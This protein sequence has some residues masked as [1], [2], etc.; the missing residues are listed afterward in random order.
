MPGIIT[1]ISGPTVVARNMRT[2]KMYNLVFVGKMRLLGE[3]IRIDGDRATIQVYEETTGL[4]LGDEI[5]DTGEPLCVELG[6]G[7]LSNIFD[8]V[9]RP[10]E[11]IAKGS[12]GF[13]STETL[14]PLNLFQGQGDTLGVTIPSLNRARKWRFVP[15]VKGG[16]EVEE[17]DIIGTIQ[18][19]T[20]ITHRVMVPPDV[21]GVI[22]EISEG[23]FSVEDGIAVLEGGTDIT[24]V[25]KWP[26]RRP[27]PFKKKAASV[28]PFITG[29]RIIDTL[30]PIAMG[31]SVIIPGGFGTGKTVLE[32]TLAKFAKTDI[33]IYIGC[34]ERGNE[35]AEVLADFPGLTDPYTG[36]PLMDRTTLVVN[37]SNMPVAA[38]EASIYTGITI[39]EYYRDMGYNVAV[40]ADSISRWAEAMR[41]I[42]GR[43]EELPGEEGFPM[44]LASRL[45]AFYERGGLVE[46]L[47]KGE[48]KGSVTVCTAISPPGGD[49]SEPVTQS[50]MRVTGAMWALDTNL[51]RRRHY[52]AINWGR[53]F[54]LYHLD[55]W[56]KE[57]VVDDWP[58]LRSELMTILQREEEL[59]DIVQL[60][61]PD[62]LRDRD[63]IVAEM[64]RLLREN[65]LQQSPYS[66]VDAFCSLEKQYW[67]LKI[68]FKV[69]ETALRELSEGRNMDEIFTEERKI[70]L[71]DVKNMRVE[72]LETEGKDIINRI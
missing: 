11:E 15:S 22:A 16:E 38:R 46:C 41:E 17:G 25:R 68:F 47:G 56:F 30:F 8:G 58:R 44:Y 60:L 10:L 66:P 35:I 12:A 2:S 29:Q 37:T 70:I 50:A 36:H 52:P 14:K 7:L 33:I 71:R 54:S 65:Y 62:S 61:G 57:C 13:I 72:K 67:M 23:E 27:R 49:F 63:R 26:V 24:L 51:A 6:P 32:Q 31:G 43:L 69:Y 55:G 53:S 48:R 5:I 42:S 3:V 28:I 34:G 45:A 20:T 9:Q 64:G 40:L 18:E 21:R 1:K 59:Q 4:T 39:G 19:T